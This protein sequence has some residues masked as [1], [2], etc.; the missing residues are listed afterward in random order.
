MTLL[1]LMM[2]AV[3]IYGEEYSDS[4]RIQ[5]HVSRSQLDMQYGDNGVRLE[6]M[7][8][9][10]EHQ[11]SADSVYTVSKV[12]VVGAASPEGAAQYNMDLSAR[13]AAAIFDYFRERVN[14]PDS[15]TRYIYL[16]RDW[17]GLYEMVS[18]DENVPERDRVLDILSEVSSGNE[19]TPSDG[20]RILRELKDAGGGESYRYMLRH[21]FPALRMSRLY[22]SYDKILS[23]AMIPA[24]R[25][26]I[27]IPGLAAG[28]AETGIGG[29][30]GQVIECRKFYMGVKTNMLYD[31]LAV[32]NIGVEFYLGRNWSLSGNWMYGWW[33][34]NVK[35]DYWR[36]YGGDVTLRYWFG[37]AAHRKPLTGHHV[38]IYGGVVTYDFEFGGTG[39]MGG[40]PG[41]SLWDRCMHVAGVEYGYSLPVARRLNIDFTLG[42]GYL[43]G[44]EEVYHPEGG[45]YIWD[46]TI[47]KNWFGPTK[48]EISLVWLIGCGN[49]NVR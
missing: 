48:A 20:D 45:E 31:A 47:R 17:R 13:R 18:V 44:K 49:H 5:F 23:P 14:L 34:R 22:V 1:M 3:N 8:S 42:I 46:K 33:S 10:L 24:L 25:S 43:G 30:Y 29:I 6:R 27:C 15:A 12:R 2:C 4:A 21:I 37:K 28:P 38:G 11:E 41:H 35:H 9:W 19:I 40:L 32:P 16:G 26:D 36:V 39:H 7:L